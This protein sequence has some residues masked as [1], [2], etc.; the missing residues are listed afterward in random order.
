MFTFVFVNAAP[1]FSITVSCST[2][3]AA[4]VALAEALPKIGSY[5]DEP[6]DYEADVMEGRILMFR[7]TDTLGSCTFSVEHVIED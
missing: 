5:S 1:P 6:S 2:Q 4:F 7:Q 3:E